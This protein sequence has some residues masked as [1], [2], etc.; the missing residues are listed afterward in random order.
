MDNCEF[1]FFI[2]IM[3]GKRQRVIKISARESDTSTGFDKRRF[4]S[5]AVLDYYYSLLV[6]MDVIPERGLI[7]H[8]TRNKGVADMIKDRGWENFMQHLE[9]VVVTIFHEFYINT[10]Q[11]DGYEVKVRGKTVSFDKSTINAYFHIRDID[12]EDEFMSY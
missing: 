5:I 3:A 8:E 2:T 10:L 9:D 1:V 7:P 11:A 6:D 4:V 12:D